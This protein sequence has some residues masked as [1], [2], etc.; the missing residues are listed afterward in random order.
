MNTRKHILSRFL[1]PYTLLALLTCA[2]TT[3]VAAQIVH[4]DHLEGRLDLYFAPEPGDGGAAQ[5]FTAGESGNVTSVTIELAQWGLPGGNMVFS[6]W[7]VD[8]SGRR[9]PGKMIGKLA[10]IE[11]NSLPELVLPILDELETVTVNGFVSGLTPGEEYYLVVEHDADATIASFKKFWMMTGA[12]ATENPGALALFSGGRWNRPFP[13]K[14]LSVRI[15]GMPITEAPRI[16]TG[17]HVSWPNGM[18]GYI[19]EVA[20]F[21][22]GPW[23]PYEGIPVE[24]EGQNIVVMDMQ[25]RSKFYRLTKAN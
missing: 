1:Q 9:Y 18:D 7:D 5:M 23:T 2:T 10:E 11:I 14:H 24:V 20:E 25:E 3:M 19:L 6:I 12:R 17:Y 21:S 8:A 4:F 13:G 22:D 16:S 15:E